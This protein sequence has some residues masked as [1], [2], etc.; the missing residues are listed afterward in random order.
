[1][2]DPTDHDDAVDHSDGTK[3]H[4]TSAEIFATN[5]DA[6][7]DTAG[8]PT[9]GTPPDP[10]AAQQQQQQLEEQAARQSQMIGKDTNGYR[11]GLSAP[12]APPAAQ[13]KAKEK[14]RAGRGVEGS[15]DD[16]GPT[17]PMDPGNKF[18][19]DSLSLTPRL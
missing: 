2:D 17:N 13:Q 6:L 18:D 9:D 3:A 14:E 10:L 11:P 7:L 8:V 15:G 19:W 12:S 4:D 16:V 5:W 1:M